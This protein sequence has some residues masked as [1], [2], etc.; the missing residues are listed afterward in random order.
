MTI[1]SRLRSSKTCSA[2]TSRRSRR[3]RALGSLIDQYGY[4]ARGARRADRKEPPV[5]EQH[6]G[7]APPPDEIK[8]AYHASP[9]VSREILISVRAR[10]IAGEAGHAVATGPA[11]QAPVQRFRPSRPENPSAAARSSRWRHAAPTGSQRLRAL[12]TGRCW[13]PRT[14]APRRACCAAP[15]RASCARSRRSWSPD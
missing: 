6:V 11:A 10:A 2:R 12:D 5:R 7:A 9:D 1:R 14:A 15:R 8:R 4:I 3:P 13:Q